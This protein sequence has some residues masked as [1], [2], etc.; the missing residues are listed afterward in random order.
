MC[1]IEVLLY[2]CGHERFSRLALPCPAGLCPE[3]NKC[4][5][6]RTRTVR[7]RRVQS[8]PFCRACFDD[9]GTEIYEALV[10]AEEDFYLNHNLVRR[11]LRAVSGRVPDNED[12]TRIRER[13]RKRHLADQE[14]LEVDFFGPTRRIPDGSSAFLYECPQ[15]S[16][17]SHGDCIEAYNLAGC[18]NPSEDGESQRGTEDDEVGRDDVEALM[19]ALHFIYE[20][21]PQENEEGEHFR[22]FLQE[23]EERARDT[24]H[25]AG[26]DWLDSTWREAVEDFVEESESSF[27]GQDFSEPY[28]PPDTFTEDSEFPS[29]PRHMLGNNT[30]VQHSPPRPRSPDSTASSPRSS[31]STSTTCTASTVVAVRAPPATHRDIRVRR[32]GP[33]LVITTR[34]PPSSPVSDTRSSSPSEDAPE[35]VSATLDHSPTM[36][37]APPLLTRRHSTDNTDEYHRQATEPLIRRGGPAP[38]PTPDQSIEDRA[39]DLR[40]RGAASRT[41][42]EQ[43]FLNLLEGTEEQG[44]GNIS[45]PTQEQGPDPWTAPDEPLHDRRRLPGLRIGDAALPSFLEMLERMREQ[46]P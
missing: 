31:S 3:H 4:Y 5:E 46:D 32:E 23:N 37:R 36:R 2:G 43:L 29:T 16:S 19:Q 30:A 1:Q 11:Y 41:A 26:I 12:Q 39:A 33:I 22:R 13:L 45:A 6:E 34:A 28:W 20:D 15:R 25:S 18:D 35:P 14:L 27:F 24:D 40:I 10:R 8:P 44:P 21:R 7:Q 9:G 38:L 42:A 17:F